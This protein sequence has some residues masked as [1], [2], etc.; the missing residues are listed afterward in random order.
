MKELMIGSKAIELYWFTGNVVGTSK[1]LETKV[2][3]SGG[4]STGQGGYVAPVNIRST[5][6]VHDQ[7]FLVDRSGKEKAFQLQDFSIA[8]R[9]TNQVSVCWAMKKGAK[10][11][12]YVLVHNHTTGNAFFKDEASRTLL[13]PSK[14]PYVLLALLALLAFAVVSFWAGFWLVVAI[15]VGSVIH[16]RMRA[17]TRVKEFNSSINPAEM[18]AT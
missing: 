17:K 2:T 8:C 12:P 13:L 18:L 3:G 15:I 10:Q 14:I 1:N 6:K 9:E 16:F 11:G 7:L 4:G 5:T